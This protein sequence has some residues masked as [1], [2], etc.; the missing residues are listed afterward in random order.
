MPP[1]RVVIIEAPLLSQAVGAALPAETVL[2]APDVA[3]AL[4]YGDGEAL[5]VL[6]LDLSEADCLEALARLRAQL[7]LRLLVYVRRPDAD[8]LRQALQAGAAGFITRPEQASIALQAVR[9]GELYAPPGV[10]K[11]LIHGLRSNH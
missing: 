5:L 6:I 10:V 3:Q 9:E 11:T 2:S 8:F 7:T 1:S 4:V